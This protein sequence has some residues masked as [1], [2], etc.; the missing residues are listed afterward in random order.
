MPPVDRVNYMP[1]PYRR[2]PDE[3]VQCAACGLMNAADARYCDQCGT[4]IMGGPTAK[5]A[6]EADETVQCPVDKSMNEPDAQF[7]DQCDTCL[8][9]Q[10]LYV[11]S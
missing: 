4:V 2:E 10:L 6:A 5:Y 8:I 1:I 7:C 11:K 3:T 9:G